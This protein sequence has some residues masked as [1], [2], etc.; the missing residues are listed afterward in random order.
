V[1]QGYRGVTLSV[2]D[3]H[4][5]YRGRRRVVARVLAGLDL[6]PGARILDAGCGGGGNLPLL[7]RYGQVTGL[8]PDASARASALQRGLGEVVEGGLE[9]L[10]FAD[11]RFDVATALDVIEHLDDDRGALVELRRVLA[12]DGFL[13]VTVPA[14]GWLWSPHDVA[15][16]HR[17][18]YERKQLL[19]AAESAGWQAVRASYFNSV[20][21]PAVAVHRLW[22]RRR[23][24][25]EAP[26][27]S[28]FERTPAWADRMLELPFRLEAALISA[29]VRVPAGLSL[30]GVFRARGS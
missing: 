20:L 9:A 29:G 19:A 25:E 14:Y 18:R 1:R 16:E 2:E 15:N 13:I 26:P 5:W 22:Q 28:D 27:V 24:G 30:L 23:I 3:R 12:E 7:A 10:P 6:P 8:E 11:G 21:L 4:W 17:R